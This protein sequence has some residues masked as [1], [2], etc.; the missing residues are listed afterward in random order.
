MMN[1]EAE[2]EEL[3]D[4]I[5]RM[6]EY[7]P[8][9]RISLK[10]AVDHP[11]F[12]RLPLELRYVFSSFVEMVWLGWGAFDRVFCPALP[13]IL[14]HLRRACGCALTRRVETDCQGPEIGLEVSSRALVFSD[15]TNSTVI[16][17]R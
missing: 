13:D 3:F 7:E 9:Q 4:L 2:H 1:N 11:F 15:I 8:T 6:L 5:G 17:N 12:A 10:E 16:A 14:I